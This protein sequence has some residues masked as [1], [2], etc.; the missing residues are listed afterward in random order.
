MFVNNLRLSIS[1]QAQCELQS[2]DGT[3]RQAFLSVKGALDFLGSLDE[4]DVTITDGSRQMR[5][6]LPHVP[7][8]R[9]SLRRE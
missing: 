3:W 6:I 9:P 4:A 2:A 5:L 1:P 8:N 7:N